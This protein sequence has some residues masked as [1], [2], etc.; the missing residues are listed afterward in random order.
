MNPFL[1]RLAT[2]TPLL[3]TETLDWLSAL[4]VSPDDIRLAEHPALK[5][6]RQ[7][8]ATKLEMDGNVA[9][10]PIQ[11]TLA[12]NPDAME[13]AVCGVEDSR[14]VVKMIEQAD[15]SKA[16]GILLRM[17]TPGGMML[18]GPE[19]ADAVATARKSKPVVAHAGGYCA[20]LGYMIASQAN[21]VMANRSAIVG[22]IGVIAS[23]ADYTALLSR[24]GIKIE[25]LTN[26]DAKYKAVG[27]IGTSLTDDH[28]DYLQAQLE[29]AFG[30][31]KSAVLSNRPLVRQSAMQGQTFRGSEA[32]GVGLV[33]S[34]GS[35]SA[36]LAMLKK[37]TSN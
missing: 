20:S 11:G 5:S 30:V 28:R 17:D 31:F 1:K 16:S 22:S 24:L 4:S 8:C 27:A 33:D 35:E 9:I 37:I 19:I 3:N 25:H 2:D 26:K 23:V 21:H 34:I 29:S 32:V 6:I 18:G 12:H 7:A 10:V 15:A 14:H 13:V 36:A